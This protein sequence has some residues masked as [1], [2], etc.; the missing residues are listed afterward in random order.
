L[1]TGLPAHVVGLV[2]IPCLNEERHI[3]AVIE[4]VLSD[5]LR[6]RLCI[7]VADGGSVDETLPIVAD[8]AVR[9]ANV[10]LLHNPRRIQSAGVNLAA[11]LYGRG[12]RWL[13]RIDAH[14]SYPAGY[15]S[16]LIAE[17]DRRRP[18]SVVVAMKAR[19]TGC[20]QA[21]A[22]AAQNSV[23][24]AGGSPHRNGSEEGFVDHGHHA[25]FDMDKFLS[26]GGYD[27]SQSHNEDAEFD[28]RLAHSG[29]K[30]WLTR[31]VDM[32]YFPRAGAGALYTQYRNYGRG[33]M[34]TILRHRLHPKLRQMLPAAVA[35]AVLLA[36]LS[37]W[38]PLA[39]VPALAWMAVCLVYGALLGLRARSVCACGAG[40]AAAIMHLGWSVGFWQAAIAAA[41]RG[42][43]PFGRPAAGLGAS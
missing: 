30:I 27:E 35:P 39:A 31:A 25:L 6:D 42:W 26:L 17:A 18:D 34:T 7:V 14:A 33:R 3:A 9:F 11:K 20:F 29:G 22:A 28:C 32:T 1:E 8:F 5:R 21:A 24:G 19:G 2:V 43:P 12:I 13:I 23:L 40:I 37:P 41:A 4:S 15:V 36:A 16:G 10:K 38:M